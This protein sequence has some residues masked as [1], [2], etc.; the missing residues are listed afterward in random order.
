MFIVWAWLLARVNFHPNTVLLLFG[1]NGVL[2]ET[3]Y[4]GA[5]A[6]IGAPF[7]ILVYGLMVYL[8]AYVLPAGR[9]A[10]KPRWFHILAALILPLL[11]AALVAIVM[12]TFSP[13]LPTSARISQN[14]PPIIAGII[15]SCPQSKSG[16]RACSPSSSYCRFPFN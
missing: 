10:V 13:Y 15:K 5:T 4:G 14:K 6:L 9:G 11:A 8:P 1:L 7:W 3:I 16:R 2:A 12:L